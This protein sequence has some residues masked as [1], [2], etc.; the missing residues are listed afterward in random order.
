MAPSLVDIHPDQLHS[1]IRT[2]ALAFSDIPAYADAIAHF[3]SV[4][5]DDRKF[6][7]RRVYAKLT[8]GPDAKIAFKFELEKLVTLMSRLS[9]NPTLSPTMAKLETRLIDILYRDL[10]RPPSTYVAALPP[11][12]PVVPSHCTYAFRDPAGENYNPLIPGLGKAGSPYAR[13][14]PS[15]NPMPPGLL[16]DPDLVFDTLLKRDKFEKHPGGI[17]A[18]FF[19]FANLIVH[20]AFHTDQSNPSINLTSS[21]LDLSIL[22]GD[23]QAQC[24]SVRNK[25]GCGKLHEDCFAD[26]RLLLMPPATCALL[27]LLSRNHNY[28]AQRIRQINERGTYKTEFANDDER[29]AQDDEIFNRARLV[30]CVYFVQIILSDYIGAILGLVRD[31]YTWRLDPLSQYRSENHELSSRGEGNVVSVEFNLLYRW[32]ATL[33]EGDEKWTRDTFREIFERED[34]ENINV[35]D[36]AKA[37]RKMKATLNEDPR[38]WTF[39][40]LE[41]GPDGRF[42]DADLAKI[43]QDATVSR[44]GAYKA[45][46]T[47][48][49]LRLIEKLGIEQARRWGTC[50]MNDFRR[51]L[52]LK[53]FESF[54]EWNPDKSVSAAAAAL[55]KDI[56][57]LELYVGLQA[58][59][60]KPPIAGAGLCPGHTISRAILADAVCLTR[61]DR[62]LTTEL[63]PFN[64]TAWGYQDC[65]RN[66]RDGS[67][68]GM[69][70][71]LLYRTLP[72][73][74]RP[75]SASHKERLYAITGHESIDTSLIQDALSQNASK[76][77]DYF[78]TKTSEL[79]KRHCITNSRTPQYVDIVQ[80]VINMLPVHWICEE[81]AGLPLTEGN[82]ASS[83]QARYTAFADVCRYVLLNAEPEY[84]WKLRNSASHISAEFIQVVKSHLGSWL[85]DRDRFLR[86]GFLNKIRSANRDAEVIAVSLFAEVVPMAAQWSHAVAHIVDF[87]LDAGREKDSKRIVDLAKL[88][89]SGANKEIGGFMR[90]ALG[91]GG[92]SGILETAL[93][94]NTAAQTLG[95]ILT[96]SGLKRAPGTSGKLN[97]FVELVNGDEQHLYVNSRSEVVPFP[98]S[99]FVQFEA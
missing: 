94:E 77:S 56:E 88:N 54:S 66:P 82:T 3:G 99:L 92:P 55:Y 46:G 73:Y 15:S 43:L 14:V 62:F 53:P 16:P 50:S 87:Y 85:L 67:Y 11:A 93:F 5:V 63:T 95:E 78:R 12:E 8:I 96:L 58:E 44:A 60:A 65:Q 49:V 69:L 19:A 74:Y 89:T 47:P 26:S 24:D 84:D 81:L 83:E 98:Q 17:N 18:L 27:V 35:E 41:R 97:R 25:D 28:S 6:L 52:G 32:H 75:R 68:G 36:F 80:D 72:A 33:S 10:P 59:E 51:F 4:G 22:Y 76:F 34:V 9:G 23:S 21:Y 45:R 71:K 42:C 30:N 86:V 70:T 20:S 40:K 39:N 48:E 79:I 61:G 38:Q 31:G 13:S 37:A 64:L 29:D 90:V 7:V 1:T 57:N 91:Q 2:N